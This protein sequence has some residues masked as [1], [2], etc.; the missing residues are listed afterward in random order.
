MPH[1]RRQSLRTT[2]HT[3]SVV[4]RQANSCNDLVSHAHLKMSF[5]KA[6]HW[7]AAEL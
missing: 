6:P 5:M 3:Y 7:I 2:L 1:C 4:V